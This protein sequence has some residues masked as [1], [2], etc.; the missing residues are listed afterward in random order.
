M[1]CVRQRLHAIFHYAIDIA[2]GTGEL[3][4]GVTDGLGGLSLSPKWLSAVSIIS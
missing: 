2:R 3:D 1:N 4:A